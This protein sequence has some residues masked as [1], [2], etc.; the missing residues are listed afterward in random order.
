MTALDLLKKFNTN[1]FSTDAAYKDKRIVVSGVIQGKIISKDQIR[2]SFTGAG[3]DVWSVE[4]L[5][6]QENQKA[7]LSIGAGATVHI[8]GTYGGETRYC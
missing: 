3:L 6:R 4:C 5:F 2:F 7:L 8:E 1:P